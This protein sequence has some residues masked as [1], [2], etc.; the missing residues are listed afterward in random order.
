MELEMLPMLLVPPPVCLTVEASWE[1]VLELLMELEL[2]PPVCSTVEASWELV[3]ELA[4][5]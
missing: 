1:P 4:R 5:V 2:D 3:L